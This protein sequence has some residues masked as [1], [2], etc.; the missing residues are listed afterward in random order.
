MGKK[1]LD[2]ACLIHGDYYKF[3]YVEILE[4]SLR[5]NF[6]TPINFHV[7]TEADRNVPGHM[8]KHD[9]SD[10]GVSGPKQ[11]WWYKTQLFDTSKFAGKLY[12]FDL[13]V[14]IT[15]SLDW[16]RKLSIEKQFWAVRDFRYLWRPNKY[17][18]NSSVMVFDATQHID[19][20]KN[21][22]YN[23]THMMKKYHG[24]QDYVYEYL[25]TTSPKM[26][27][28]FDVNKVRSFRWQVLHGGMEFLTRQ[29]PK[30]QQIDVEIGPD[31]SIVVFHGDPKPHQI[32]KS[33][34]KDH[35]Y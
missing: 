5:R 30:K 24:D 8:I 6:D 7:W 21:F 19:L 34:L 14:I 15:G 33:I 25:K 4:R 31:T 1:L 3:E 11:S 35:W 16:M 28:Y 27:R 12:Y 20:W 2:C 18:I 10:L 22:A 26:I 32:E 17:V 13:D 23:K 9:L 29:Y